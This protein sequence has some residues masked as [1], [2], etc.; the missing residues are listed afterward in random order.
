[1]N[2]MPSTVCDPRVLAEE[3][4]DLAAQAYQTLHDPLTDA[5]GTRELSR[6]IADLQGVIGGLASD[7]LSL[8][9]ENLRRRVDAP[10]D[11]AAVGS[12]PR[13]RIPSALE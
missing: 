13:R 4:R 8:W 1:M 2:V 7:D 3:I 6:R 5:R 11:P 9:L 12:N 10:A